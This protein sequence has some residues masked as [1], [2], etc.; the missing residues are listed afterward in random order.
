MWA[1]TMP[2]YS[3]YQSD[4]SRRDTNQ[5]AQASASND[6][7]GY[8]DVSPHTRHS[9]IDLDEYMVPAI[10]GPPSPERI[11]QLSKQMK[12]ASHLNRGHRAVSSG[13]SSFV[14]SERGWEQGFENMS[15]TRHS[16]QRSTTSG[17]S[18]S[19]DRPDSVQVLGKNIFHRRAKSSKSGRSR[20]E[21]SAQ[22]SSGSSLYS[23]EL[24]SE[25]SLT[26]FKDA[27][28]P[29]IFA[30]RKSS[31]DETA[32]QKKLQI[33]GPFNFQHVTHTPRE[34]V[35]NSAS[36]TPGQ[37]HPQPNFYSDRVV[38]HEVS[39]RSSRASN[40]PR[41]LIKHARSQEQLRTSPPRPVRPPRPPPLEPLHSPTL[42]APIPPPRSSSRQP[43]LQ[44]G[45]ALAVARFD[46]PLTSGGFRHPQPFS[47]SE[48]MERPPA[49]S[50]GYAMAPEQ[51]VLPVDDHRFSHAI[52]TPDDAAWPLP[53]TASY[54]PPLPDVPEEEEHMV[55]IGR[56]PKSIISTRSSLRA[57][58]S[59][60][61]LR[62]SQTLENDA[63]Q[64]SAGHYNGQAHSIR[65]SWEDDIDYCYEHEADA[66]F[67]YEWERP[68]L[69][70]GREHAPGVQVALFEDDEL[71]EL[72]IIGTAESSPGM[73]SASRF[74]MPALSPASQASPESAFEAVTPSTGV[75]VT[76][77][78]S[79]PRG[80]KVHRPSNLSHCRN[81]SR[82]SSFKESYGFTLSPSL[83][84]PGDYHQ[85]ML[86]NETERQSY[87]GED[88]VVHGIVDPNHP[89]EDVS[90]A[91][92]HTSLQMSHQRASTS[93]TATNS[94]SLSDSTG[95][96]HVS[97]NSTWTNLTRLTSSTSLNKWVESNNTIR[98][99]QIIK[100]HDDSDEEE[101]TPPASTEKDTV[102]E[103]TPFPSVPVTKKPHHKSHASESI[104]RDDIPNNTKSVELPKTRRPRARTTS[105][106][107]QAPPV[108]QYA[109]FPRT[110][111]KGNGDRI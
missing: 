8:R 93:T 108:G 39:P 27:I 102:P 97:T 85:Q 28:M 61:L 79:L 5:N 30:R 74:D 13:S 32:L 50:H 33:S 44:D 109:L 9:P 71:R 23:T 66:N 47:P 111:A 67:D 7:H 3:E 110:Y 52:T 43:S 15:I 89:Y 99:S 55:N 17:T 86:L 40:L 26:T 56:S 100:S 68:S 104:V 22:S 91:A 46:R 103:L 73:L 78:F 25:T 29:T 94:T 18:S 75:A 38:E 82:A 83:L 24:S 72:P 88:D 51:A 98:E 48:I 76:N 21:S 87:S 2:Y 34:Q 59:V 101:T 81:D 4:R 41:R 92:S 35:A 96:R 60:P 62:G 37:E 65:E 19:R 42:G 105:L 69:E 11:R 49:T 53:V 45:D 16:S 90:N 58:Q 80:D 63:A 1:A 20:R 14:N 95:E 31:R 12:H 77:N 84:I 106:S 6:A 64:H 36:R 57:S 54:E 107:T 70:G 10:E